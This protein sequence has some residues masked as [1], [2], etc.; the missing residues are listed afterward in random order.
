MGLCRPETVVKCGQEL[1]SPLGRD[2]LAS[3]P[4]RRIG[5]TLDQFR[6]LEI[7]EQVGHDGAVDAEM[8]RQGKLA[9]HNALGGSRKHL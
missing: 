5:A 6:R 3:P 9:S 4:I 1:P 2:N 8:L 7:I